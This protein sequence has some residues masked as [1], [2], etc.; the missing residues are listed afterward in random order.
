MGSEALFLDTCLAT[1]QKA[2][3]HFLLS[4]ATH[5]LGRP[6]VTD[7]K[8]EVGGQLGLCLAHRET[9]HETRDPEETPRQ[10][11]VGS[12][13]LSVLGTRVPARLTRLYVG[14]VFLRGGQA[15]TVF[16]QKSFNRNV[17]LSN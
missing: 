8:R 13:S 17:S 1:S 2:A 3:C 4:F 10:P 15:A 12:A 11:H 16:F 7:P 14:L 6:L 9:E 5:Y